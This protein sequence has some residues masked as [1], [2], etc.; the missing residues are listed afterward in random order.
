MAPG[1]FFEY[2][3]SPSLPN[4]NSVLNLRIVD[5]QNNDLTVA[6]S[7]SGTSPSVSTSEHPILAAEVVGF[8]SRD[9]VLTLALYWD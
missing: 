6:P 4:T 1:A 5:S 8:L 2:S 7:L 9:F 3:T